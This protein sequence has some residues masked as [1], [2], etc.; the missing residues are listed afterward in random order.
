MYAGDD[1]IVEALEH[2]IETASSAQYNVINNEIYAIEKL[3][4][5]TNKELHAL[6]STQVRIYIYRER[7]LFIHIFSYVHICR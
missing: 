4:E 7:E 3:I 6:Q 5:E 1:P 2:T